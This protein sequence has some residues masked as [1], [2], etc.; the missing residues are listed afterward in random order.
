MLASNKQLKGWSV[1]CYYRETKQP[2]TA[3]PVFEER[4]KSGTHILEMVL[5]GNFIS[6]K[7]SSVS[8]KEPWKRGI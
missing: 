5:G 2:Q 6:P 7:A 4:D 1:R 3:H 8:V